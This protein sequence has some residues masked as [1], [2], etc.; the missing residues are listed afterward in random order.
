MHPSE[1]YPASKVLREARVNKLQSPLVLPNFCEHAA[2]SLSDLHIEHIPPVPNSFSGLR[3]FSVIAYQD[4]GVSK[5]HCHSPIVRE[6]A[7]QTSQS[8][9]NLADRFQLVW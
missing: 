9:R 6:G 2:V 8:R 4:L 1:E 7:Q 5:G 3:S